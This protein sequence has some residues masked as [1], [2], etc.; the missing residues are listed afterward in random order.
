MSSIWEK[1]EDE[2]SFDVITDVDM[3]ER[4]AT[5]FHFPKNEHT[6]HVAVDQNF[7]MHEEQACF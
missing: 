6:A 2:L 5:L 4:I 1:I 3:K 7:D